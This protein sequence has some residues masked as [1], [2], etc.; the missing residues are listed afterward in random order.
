MHKK[1]NLELLIIAIGCIYAVTLMFYR[2]FF[3]TGLVDESYHVS[4]SLAMMHG[5]LPYVYNWFVGCDMDF[6]LI[7]FLFVY[8]CFAPDLDGIFDRV[9]SLDRGVHILFSCRFLL[10]SCCFCTS[11]IC[12]KYFTV[13]EPHYNI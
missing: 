6:L 9:A 11:N 7:P 2:C 3:G 13:Y 10:G 1:V 4:D 12:N 5:N 8:E